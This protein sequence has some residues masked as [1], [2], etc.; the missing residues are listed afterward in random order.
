[1]MDRDSS[2]SWTAILFERGQRAVVMVDSL[3]SELEQ[4]SQCRA[5]M[6][7]GTLSVTMRSREA[8]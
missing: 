3:L 5:G 8:V 7:A 1:M 6:T 4:R 2:A